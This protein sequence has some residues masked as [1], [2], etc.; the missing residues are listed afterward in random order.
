MKIICFIIILSIFSYFA[1][2]ALTPAVVSGVDVSKIWSEYDGTTGVKQNI[3]MNYSIALDNLT[4]Q[5]AP[6][7]AHIDVSK[8]WAEYDGNR[9]VL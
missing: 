1:E 4:R 5:T 8:I 3:T 2:S 6:P 9:Q 7:I